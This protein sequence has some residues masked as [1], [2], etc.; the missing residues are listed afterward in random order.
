MFSDFKNHVIGAPQI[1]PEFGVG[2]GN[3]QFDGDGL[4]EDFGLEQISGDPADRYKFRTA[5]LR[6]AALSPAFFHNGSFTRIEDAIVHHLDVLRSA[7]E[8]DAR[9]AG[10]KRDLTHILGPIQPVLDRLDPLLRHPV[11]LS[12][13]EVEALVA[14]VRDGLLDP[15][16]RPEHLC[17]LV[18]LTVPSGSP[19]LKFQVCHQPSL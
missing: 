11:D 10:V 1:A 16:A 9:A 5:P 19:V 4:N 8:Y 6:N 2:K 15:R 13:E 7:T 14:F 12:S 17:Q 18:P 3:V